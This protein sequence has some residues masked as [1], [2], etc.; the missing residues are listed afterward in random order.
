MPRSSAKSKPSP[1]VLEDLLTEPADSDEAA[2]A[3]AA[4]GS[5]GIGDEEGDEE[6]RERV[7]PD[8][9]PLV[10]IRDNVYFPHMIFPLFVGR[11]KS[12]KALDAAMEGGRFILLA[13]QK[14]LATE[15]PEPDD[16]HGMGIAAE[17]MQILKVPDGTVRV[18]LEG[19]RRVRLAQFLQTEPY[20]LVKTEPVETEEEQSLEIEALTRSITAQF[21]QI[22]NLGK[23]IPPEA[24]I[25]VLNLD[26][27]GRLADTITPYLSLRVEQKQQ[28]LETLN[29]RERL[30]KLGAVLVKEYE[31]LEIQKNI[32]SRVEKEMG[33]TQ[34]EFILREQLK[35]IQQ[36]LGERDEKGSEVDDYR[37]KIEAAQMPPDTRERALKELDR[38]EKTPF[39]SP[40]RA[41][42]A[43]TSIG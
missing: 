30:E 29:V 35:A 11:E 4:L 33:D 27:G 41:S 6:E 18:M 12:V 7:V 9:L 31:I 26:D 38:F 8:V 24:L 3:V 22:V 10:P 36:E 32:R 40:R 39:A 16:V 17:V 43:P 28:I 37:E 5:L 23:N 34:R 13:A 2:A 14:Q 19:V 25:N 21:E 1:P 42:S 20:L 15:D